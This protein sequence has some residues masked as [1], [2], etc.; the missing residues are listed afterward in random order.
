MYAGSIIRIKIRK[1]HAFYRVTAQR[2]NA[3]KKVVCVTYDL[4]QEGRMCYLRLSAT[5]ARHCR[6]VLCKWH[7]LLMR[8]NTFRCAVNITKLSGH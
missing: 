3:C 7:D 4:L 5:A 1:S 6:A 2:I 8:M